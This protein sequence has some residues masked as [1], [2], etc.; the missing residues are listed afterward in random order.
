MLHV[1]ITPE[2]DTKIRMSPAFLRPP[3][4]QG[5]FAAALTRRGLALLTTAP[6]PSARCV[7]A[8]QGSN[9][10]TRSAAAGISSTR[11]RLPSATAGRPAHAAVAHELLDLLLGRLNFLELEK[12]RRFA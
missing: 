1:A 2:T 5:L 11:L 4:R 7:T 12:R 9:P 6:W 8:A 10:Q 3:R